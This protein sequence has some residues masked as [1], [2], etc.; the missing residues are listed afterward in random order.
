MTPTWS[1]SPWCCP[2]SGISTGT[3]PKATRCGSPGFLRSKRPGGWPGTAF[4]PRP[5]CPPA[6]TAAGRPRVQPPA[7][8]EYSRR[9]PAS[10]GGG[11]PRA[12]PAVSA[13]CRPRGGRSPGTGGLR[14]DRGQGLAEIS[15]AVRVGEDGTGTADQF[16]SARIPARLPQRGCQSGHL[17]GGGAAE[18]VEPVAIGH[19]PLQHPP[20]HARATQPQLW[21]LWPERLRL[22]V[23]VAERVV[24]ARERGRC[25]PPQHPPRRQMLIEQV[26]TLAEGHPE[27]RVLV[28]QP[29]HGRL[30]DQPAAAEQVE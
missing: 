10:T 17:L 15:H 12:P 27:R 3:C 8:R 20:V 9:P 24:L 18:R 7:A 26:A 4:T 23:D 13:V 11:A 22:E 30:H 1:T 5:G 19:D 28:L 21:A 2:G 6:S 16:Q 29:G 14:R 25:V